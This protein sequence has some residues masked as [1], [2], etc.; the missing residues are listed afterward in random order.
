[1][2]SLN[3][4]NIMEIANKYITDEED[5]NKDEINDILNSKKERLY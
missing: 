4:S 1:M 3:D 5:L 2:Q